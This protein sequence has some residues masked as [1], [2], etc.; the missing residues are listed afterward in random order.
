M[1]RAGQAR[2]ILVVAA[3]L[4]SRLV[5]PTDFSTYP[6]FGDGA[7]AVLLE[8]AERAMRP[9]LQGSVLHADGR[10]ADLIRIETGGSRLPFARMADPRQ[11]YLQMNGRAVFEFAVKRGAE[12]IDEL[13]RVYSVPKEQVR[14][15]V[16][17]QANAK[18]LAAI[19]RET[20][21]PPERFVINL[22]RYGN[23][24][25]AST[26]IAFD[27]LAKG[28]PAKH[29]AGPTLIAAFGAGL[30]WGGILIALP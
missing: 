27:E 2:R 24:A 4:M 9:Y 18:I 23:T 22:D 19:G 1:L 26:L 20:G 7:G 3:D 16:L 5:N 6:Y 21:L 14:H 28:D 25:A 11:Q 12:V 13:C 30:T 8:G 17:H 15:L 10:G 29:L